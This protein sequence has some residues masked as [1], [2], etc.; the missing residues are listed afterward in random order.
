MRQK[1]IRTI[2]DALDRST[3]AIAGGTELGAAG[4]KYNTPVSIETTRTAAVTE[5]NTYETA[6]T[7]LDTKQAEVLV[8]LKAAIIYIAYARDLLMR[9]LGSKYS[10]A[11]DAAGFRRSLRVPRSIKD[12]KVALEALNGYFTANASRQNTELNITAAHALTLFNNLCTAENAMNLQ[13]SAVGT[14]KKLR[15]IKFKALKAQ[16][17]RL[18]KE[19]GEILDPLDSRW[20][21]F[22]FNKPGA[23]ETPPAPTGVTAVLIGATAVSVKWQAAARAD[24]YRVWVRVEGEE[25][26]DPM[27]SP[28]DLDQT[29]EGLSANTNFEIAVSAVNNGGESA[30]SKV[31]KVTTL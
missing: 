24:H 25:N 28:A 27:G 14:A 22:G 7:V 18:F 13:K 4:P 29:L 30:K 3:T 20:V 12:V 5:R 8:A 1:P 31:A 16:L 21:L 11:W 9:H 26:F 6:R 17:T 19:L 23:K 15:D 10:E 2:A